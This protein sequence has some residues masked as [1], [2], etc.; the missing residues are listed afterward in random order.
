LQTQNELEMQFEAVTGSHQSPN[1][2]V[3]SLSPMPSLVSRKEVQAVAASAGK[4]TYCGTEPKDQDTSHH[5]SGTTGSAVPT[6]SD[7]GVSQTTSIPEVQEPTIT[8]GSGGATVQAYS[9][10][11]ALQGISV[12]E[13]QE[14]TITSALGGS[15][16]GLKRVVKEISSAANKKSKKLHVVEEV[17]CTRAVST[18]D[19][20]LI[21]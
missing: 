14:P 6:S 7:V 12:P 9:D 2:G 18:L 15:G 1:V 8:S 10:P 20:S 19:S 17:E 3:D 4:A 21:T 11:G 13:V 5:S 16:T